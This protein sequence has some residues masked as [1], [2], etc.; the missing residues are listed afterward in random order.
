[1]KKILLVSSALLFSIVSFAENYTFRQNPFTGRQD[2][3]HNISSTSA[4]ELIDISTTGAINGDCFVYNS[5]TFQWEPGSCGGGSG[6]SSVLAVTTGSATGFSV[7]I[8]SPTSVVN[9]SSGVFIVQLTPTT[10]A[11]VSLD[12]S[13]V[14]LQGQN[15]ITT[16]SQSASNLVNQG[17]YVFMSSQAA[18][19][20]VN[21]GQYMFVS[22]QAASNLVNQ[23]QYVFMS[24]QAASNLVNQG[25]Y[26]F[27]SSQA[28]SNLVNQGQYMF[29]SSQA[30][31]NLVNQGQYFFAGSSLTLIGIIHSSDSV[32]YTALSTFTVF[33]ASLPATYTAISTFTV[34]KSSLTELYLGI[35]S[36]PFQPRYFIVSLT[37][38]V[39]GTIPIGNLTTSAS[40]YLNWPT[41]GTANF[42]HA[43]ITTNTITGG[44]IA[45]TGLNC[46]TN[47]NGGAISSIGGNF[48]CTD[49]DSGSG[50]YFKVSLTTGVTDT[51]GIANLT[52]NAS[53]YLNW[54]ST[55]TA[56]FNDAIVTTNTI[57]GS[58]LTF[59]AIYLNGAPGTPPLSVGSSTYMENVSS[60]SIVWKRAPLSDGLSA[61][62]LRLIVSTENFNTTALGTPNIKGNYT[63]IRQ[64][65]G[66]ITVT[67]KNDNLSSSAISLYK[68]DPSNIQ[69]FSGR[70]LKFWDIASAQGTSFLASDVQTSANIIY[71]LPASSGSVE[72]VL[73]RTNSSF[74]MN[75]VSRSSDTM[76]SVTGGTSTTVVAI[77]TVGNMGF[78][79]AA[80]TNYAFNFVLFSSAAAT[81]TGFALAVT[82]TAT[83][84]TLIA[85]YD[86]PI[87]T[88]STTRV[89]V[90]N[91]TQFISNTSNGTDLTPIY[92]NGMIRTGATAGNIN[93]QFGSEVATSNVTIAKGSHGN[94][95]RLYN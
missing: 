52:R 68:L 78:P 6:A 13:S 67:Y 34:F 25:Q 7:V 94:I 89:R 16:S 43:V 61:N 57:N 95:R 56:N 41:T 24:S 55:G 79:V 39:S 22:S 88:G 71:T 62:A 19:N 46:S 83:I 64:D 26:V 59:N 1:M 3:M 48:F 63:E 29:V 65:T 54:P 9:F 15:V 18:S 14:T 36:A 77:S 91:G 12:P 37:T 47:T 21:Q 69:L 53:T 58:T 8:A 38:G 11:F 20:L 76:V 60:N 28:A 10:T 66:S 49:D 45:I 51:I 72:Q 93:L 30:A 35:S 27:M 84:N 44:T 40:T 75:W 70:N 23:G 82:S 90:G 42:N 81:T 50:G 33:G 4:G 2:M 5:V 86:A 32:A 92:I 73:T 31:S 85:S 80:N 87:S 17:Q 74:E